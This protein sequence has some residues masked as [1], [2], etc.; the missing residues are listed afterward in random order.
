[1]Q[2]FEF[3]TVAVP[4]GPVDLSKHD[5]ETTETSP[6]KYLNFTNTR[7]DSAR[8]LLPMSYMPKMD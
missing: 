4:R 2:K 8:K 7:Y 5:Q 1:M 3:G 6:G